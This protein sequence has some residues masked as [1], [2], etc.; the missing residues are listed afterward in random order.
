MFQLLIAEGV[1]LT[2]SDFIFLKP[3][4][5]LQNEQGFCKAVSQ[6]WARRLKYKHKGSSQVNICM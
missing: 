4:L 3:F 1:N 2:N 6:T 5:K